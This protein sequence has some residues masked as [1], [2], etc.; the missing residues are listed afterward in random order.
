MAY[1]KIHLEICFYV[2][3]CIHIFALLYL[4]LIMVDKPCVIVTL[5]VPVTCNK[6]IFMR[7]LSD[8]LFHFNSAVYKGPT[9]PKVPWPLQSLNTYNYRSL[10]ILN[11]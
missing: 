1:L 2:F 7:E 3:A 11:W 10:S 8:F 9:G 5:V 4:L 6:Q